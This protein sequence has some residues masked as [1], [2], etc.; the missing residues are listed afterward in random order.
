MIFYP[1]CYICC[2]GLYRSFV[3]FVVFNENGPKGLQGAGLLGVMALLKQIWPQR[4]FVIGVFEVSGAQ[5]RSSISL[6]LMP[7]Y[8]DIKPSASSLA[9]CLPPCC[10]SLH[11]DDKA[12]HL[13]TVGQRLNILPYESCVVMESLHRNRNHNSDVIAKNNS[14]TEETSN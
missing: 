8:S 3:L 14:P 7:A 5:T 12:L 1:F 10:L 9:P 4:T 13:C 6:I 11:H 2:F